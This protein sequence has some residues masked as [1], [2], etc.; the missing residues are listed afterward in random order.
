MLDR[1]TN[2]TNNVE[3]GTP[4]VSYQNSDETISEEVASSFPT[5]RIVLASIASVGLVALGTFAYSMGTQVAPL[6]PSPVTTTSLYAQAPVPSA[7][8]TVSYNGYTYATL[9]GDSPYTAMSYVCADSSRYY[10]LPAGWEIAPDDANSINVIGMYGWNYHVLY[11]AS[12]CG[13][14]TAQFGPPRQRWSCNGQYSGNQFKIP[15]CSTNFLIRKHNPPPPTPVPISSPTAVPISHPTQFPTVEPTGRPQAGPTHEPIAHPTLAP[16]DEPIAEPSLAP[17]P[18]A[19][20][21]PSMEPT[22]SPTVKATEE[23]KEVQ[24]YCDYTFEKGVDVADKEILPGC[25]MIAAN[26]MN[27]MTDGKI[28][29]V[30]YVCSNAELQINAAQLEASLESK[31]SWIKV[32]PHATLTYNGPNGMSGTFSEKSA[33]N[34][35]VTI[36]Y[37]DGQRVNDNI[38]SIKLA[39]TTA[40]ASKLPDECENHHV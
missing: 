20:A 21:A 30:I 40:D 36:T 7:G 11:T 15:Y 10:Y 6:T 4:L 27:F 12:N 13:Y 16:T 34:S 32:G 25:A 22:F 39:S 17:I 24:G 8:N 38:Q 3:E 19:T 35:L 2:T 28:S 33:D 23:P 37:K 29:K 18:D 5:K 1:M 9:I 14:H 26:D 31:I